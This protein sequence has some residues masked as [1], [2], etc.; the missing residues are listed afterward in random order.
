MPEISV[1]VP[2]YKVEKYLSSCVD[3]ILAQTFTDF[4][5]ILV[6]DGSPDNC[7]VI[8]DEYA[9]KDIRI[10][11]IHQENQGPSCARNTG[12]NAARGNYL[13]FVDSDDLVTPDYCRVL[14]ELLTESEA[15]FSVCGVCRFRDGDTPEPVHE[16]DPGRISSVEFLKMQL[17][18]QSEFGVWNKL[19]RRELFEMIRFAE[20]KL[21]EDVIFS[22]DLLSCCPNG[23]IFSGKQLYFYRQREDS[24]VSVQAARGSLDLIYAGA[25]LLEKVKKNAPECTD[26]AL[27]YTLAYPWMFVDPIYVN[28]TFRENR[29][30]LQGIQDFLKAHISEYCDRCIFQEI[31][32]KRMNLFARS[33]YLYGLNAYTRLLRVYLFHM[34]GKDAYADGHG[35]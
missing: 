7:G 1:I 10:R 18:R 26:A 16:E 13:C 28:G 11:V 15:D 35:I 29:A 22:A 8:C 31:Q 25:Y 5:L 17:Q 24:I 23:A 9:A 12:I 19:F 20:G 21:N 27:R 34:I 14:Y 32:L 33:R 4:E 6:D 3:S 30:F 2:V